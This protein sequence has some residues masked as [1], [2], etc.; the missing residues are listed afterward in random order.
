MTIRKLDKSDWLPF[1]A[2]VSKML[3]GTRAEIEVASLPIG[4]Q[5]EAEWLPFVGIAYDPK[6]D[7]IE[8]ALEGVD[9]LISKPRQVFVD[10]AAGDFLSLAII[11]Q[12]GTQHILKLREPLVLPSP[13]SVR[14]T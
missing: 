8:V 2:G 10:E 7:V 1:F 11:D 14:Q 4:D 6:D 3:A 13:T 5:I 9:H 12:D